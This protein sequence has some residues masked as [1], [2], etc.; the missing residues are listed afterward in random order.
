ML[1]DCLCLILIV[2]HRFGFIFVSHSDIFERSYIMY[3]NKPTIAIYLFT[4]KLHNIFIKEFY[5]WQNKLCPLNSFTK[6]LTK[7]NFTLRIFT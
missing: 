4:H 1:A 3:N 6:P 7:E 5:R 2:V